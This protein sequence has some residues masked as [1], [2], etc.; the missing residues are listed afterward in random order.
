MISLNEKFD[1][2]DRS[3]VGLNGEDFYQQDGFEV[4]DLTDMDRVGN[5]VGLGKSIY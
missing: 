3:S 1:H 5:Q 4:F 2:F